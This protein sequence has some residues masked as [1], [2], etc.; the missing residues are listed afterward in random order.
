MLTYSRQL[1]CMQVIYAH[2]PVTRIK[3]K[4]NCKIIK[5]KPDKYHDNLKKMKS[6]YKNIIVIF[7]T[8]QLYDQVRWPGS[9]GQWRTTAAPGSENRSLLNLLGL[10]FQGE[11]ILSHILSVWPLLWCP[12]MPC[13]LCP[14][15]VTSHISSLELCRGMEWHLSWWWGLPEDK[16]QTK[17]NEETLND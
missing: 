1:Y 8:N 4:K 2:W 9:F 3:I 15:R 11:P 10:L 5:N 6:C 7:W 17:V 12:L 13:S 14:L 16:C